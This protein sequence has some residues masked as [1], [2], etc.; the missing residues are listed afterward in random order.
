M[1][2][3]KYGWMQIT[4]IDRFRPYH[5][6]TSKHLEK[7]WAIFISK[8]DLRAFR[9]V[10]R[11]SASLVNFYEKEEVTPELILFSIQKFSIYLSGFVLFSCCLLG[12]SYGRIP[13]IA[14]FI[15]LFFL[16]NSFVCGAMAGPSPRYQ[17]R[18]V[19]ILP[20]FGILLLTRLWNTR[21]ARISA[22]EL[23]HP[24]LCVCLT[25]LFP[26]SR[27]NEPSQQQAFVGNL[28]FR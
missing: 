16:T 8:R 3:F 21:S 7:S 15:V 12:P 22:R 9:E 4:Y 5:A 11:R 14:R 26:H 23:T 24:P 20:L 6:L 1:A 10:R 2:M 25:L 28:S 18:L 19:W 17:L 13:Q 27:Q